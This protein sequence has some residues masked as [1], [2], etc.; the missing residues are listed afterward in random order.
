V[1]VGEEAEAAVGLAGASV[2]GPFWPHAD[3]KGSRAAKEPAAVSMTTRAAK[4]C[5]HFNIA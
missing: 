1:V 2:S 3:S 5:R 4:L